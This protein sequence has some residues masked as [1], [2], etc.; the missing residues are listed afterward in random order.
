MPRF[1]RRA[2]PAGAAGILSE[3]EVDAMFPW[4]GTADLALHLE[5]LLNEA[6]IADSPVPG[7]DPAPDRRKCPDFS[8]L[9]S[10]ING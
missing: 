1:L 3:K 2:R 4:A 10:T 5:L 6:A 7:P 8:P 9:I